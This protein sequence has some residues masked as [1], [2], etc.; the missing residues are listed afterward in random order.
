ML[1]LLALVATLVGTGFG[2]VAPSE[3][4]GGGPAFAAPIVYDITGGGPARLP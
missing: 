2:T 4:T 3:V 1:S